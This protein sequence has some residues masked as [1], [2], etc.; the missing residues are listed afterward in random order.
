[1][2]EMVRKVIPKGNSLRNFSRLNLDQISFEI[3][4]MP[5]KR[6]DYKSTFEIELNY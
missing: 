6:F 4:F 2:N 1:M 5:K 3:I